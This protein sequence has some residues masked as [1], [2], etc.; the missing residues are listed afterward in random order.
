VQGRVAI[1][2][3]LV[4]LAAG[5]G[6]GSAEKTV[7]S[8]TVYLRQTTTVAVTF[9]GPRNVEHYCDDWIAVRAPQGEAWS[10]N[11]EKL[12]RDNACAFTY[13]GWVA[14]VDDT[15]GQAHAEPLCN[16]LVDRWDKHVPP[17]IRSPA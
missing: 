13:E 10:R 16:W 12:A 8:C 3:S 11:G 1:G 17:D 2:A 5:C 14:Q 9:K 7:E 4:V 15:G 6:R